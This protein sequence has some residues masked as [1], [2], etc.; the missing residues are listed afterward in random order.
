MKK[1]IK[2]LK[3]KVKNLKLL[4]VEDNKETRISTIPLFERFF[5]DI[6]TA[7]DGQDGFD[8]FVK[9]KPDI[10]FTDINMPNIDG[11]KMVDKINNFAGKKVPVLVFSAHG[12][13]KYLINAIKS[14]VDGYLIKPVEVEQFIEELYRIINK[15][16]KPKMDIVE[17]NKNYNWDKK[18]KKLYYISDEIVLTKNEILLFELMTS[19]INLTYSDEIIIEQI[20]SLFLEADKTNVKNLLK[21]LNDKLP[22]KLIKNIYSVGYSFI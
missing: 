14:G 17:I 13:S 10:I 12:E 11:L 21:R 20:W 1:N 9:F 7:T 3:E 15:K 5:D 22:Q 19:N 16:Y 4:Y 6:I 8:K 2:I 18:T